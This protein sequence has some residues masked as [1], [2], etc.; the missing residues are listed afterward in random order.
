MVAA[1]GNRVLALVKADEMS[2]DGITGAELVAF[3][4]IT[5]VIRRCS[6]TL[7]YFANQELLLK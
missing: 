5:D 1:N 4:L 2:R 6:S 7:A 3:I